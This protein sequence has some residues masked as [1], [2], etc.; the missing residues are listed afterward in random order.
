MARRLERQFSH[1][2]YEELPS[3]R[4]SNVGPCTK[5]TTCVQNLFK[6]CR[7]HYP[8]H[9]GELFSKHCTTPT[10]RFASVSEHSTPKSTGGDSCVGS[11]EAPPL[12]LPT[13]MVEPTPTFHDSIEQRSVGGTFPK[14]VR[15][16]VIKEGFQEVGRRELDKVWANF[17][18]EANVPFAVARNAAFKD[19]VMKTAAFKKPY[20]PPSYH[21]IRTRL[22]TQAKADLEVQLDNRLAESVRK[23]GGTLTVDGWTSVSSRPLLNA[24]LVSPCWRALLGSCRYY[25]Q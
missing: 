25:E 20:V 17:F 11:T 12:I 22:L 18:Y 7:G 2:G 10:L 5:L 23:F 6:H 19:A 3:K 21:D 9:N 13:T 16:S 14:L 15:Q 24:M 4:N 8:K 1:L